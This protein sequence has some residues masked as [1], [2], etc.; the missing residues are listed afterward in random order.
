MNAPVLDRLEDITQRPIAIERAMP[1]N[2]MIRNGKRSA[3][4]IVNNFW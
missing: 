2:G 1:R 4:L 3:E